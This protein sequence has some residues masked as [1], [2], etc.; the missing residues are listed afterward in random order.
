MLARDI[1]RGR[2]VLRLPGSRLR[3][4]LGL[5]GDLARLLLRRHGEF[6]RLLLDGRGDLLC[7]VLRL[8]ATARLVARRR[9]IDGLVDHVLWWPRLD[10]Q[11]LLC[12][13]TPHVDQTG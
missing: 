6:L 2:L 4:L 8:L 13:G 11:P 1:L 9:S 5:P 10:L 12:H 3:V 7:L